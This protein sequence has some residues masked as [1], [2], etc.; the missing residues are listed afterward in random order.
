MEVHNMNS[1]ELKTLRIKALIA[2]LKV[3]VHEL[4]MVLAQHY[5]WERAKADPI[6]VYALENIEM[7]KKQE[8]SNVVPE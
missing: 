2:V 5:G 1:E 3:V 8:A 6:V 7:I 4:Q